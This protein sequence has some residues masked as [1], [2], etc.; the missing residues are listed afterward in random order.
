MIPTDLALHVLLC[1]A[2]PTIVEGDELEFRFDLGDNIA[3]IQATRRHVE[4]DYA[5]AAFDIKYVDI[6]GR[7]V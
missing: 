7:C 1:N 2:T 3:I 5:T 6:Q 4:S